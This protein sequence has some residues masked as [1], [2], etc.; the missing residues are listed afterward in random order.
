MHFVACHTVQVPD[1]GYMMD[2]YDVSILQPKAL[3]IHP[4]QQ[5]V[6]P[7]PESQQSQTQ[8]PPA[9]IAIRMPVTG[10]C[11]PVDSTA[12]GADTSPDTNSRM[13]QASLHKGPGHQPSHVLRAAIA[14]AP[15]TSTPAKS[16]ISTQTDDSWNGLVHVQQVLAERE[17]GQK[18]LIQLKDQY[19]VQEARSRQLYHGQKEARQRCAVLEL[20]VQRLKLQI[21]SLQQ[22]VHGEDHSA[23]TRQHDKAACMPIGNDS[24]GRSILHGLHDPRHAQHSSAS[25]SRLSSHVG[26]HSPIHTAEAQSSAH[27]LGMARNMCPAGPYTPSQILE[28]CTEA[29]QDIQPGMVRGSH[30]VA[31]QLGAQVAFLGRAGKLLD[32][33]YMPNSSS[34]SSNEGDGVGMDPDDKSIQELAFGMRCL[35]IEACNAKTASCT[36]SLLGPD[37]W[38]EKPTKPC[39]PAHSTPEPGSRPRASKASG[40]MSPARQPPG[41]ARS[42]SPHRAQNFSI[43]HTQHAGSASEAITSSRTCTARGAALGG[44]H[45]HVDQTTFEPWHVS[46]VERPDRADRLRQ[47]T[48]GS[49]AD[50]AGK[51]TALLAGRGSSSHAG[52]SRVQPPQGAATQ[53]PSV[54]APSAHG[55]QPASSKA[56]K[57]PPDQCQ[58]GCASHPL[59]AELGM[60]QATSSTAIR[61]ATSSSATH[62]MAG[63][64]RVNHTAAADPDV[65]VH[66]VSCNTWLCSAK[67]I[68]DSTMSADG[69]RLLWVD[70]QEWHVRPAPTQVEY[71]LALWC[72]VQGCNERVG[73]LCLPPAPG[74]HAAW[75]KEVPQ[76]AWQRCETHGLPGAMCLRASA[77]RL[78]KGLQ[79]P[80]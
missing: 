28:G 34:R 43:I 71:M 44:G 79:Q 45:G 50:S 75:M 35:E 41:P 77:C 51:I 21:H 26:V 78:V 20:E 76:A 30:A 74:V 57:C 10:S 59:S 29:E 69:R 8:V 33:S 1:A 15:D 38:P 63:P 11:A 53:C 17:A 37:G 9:C 6:V 64:A 16:A 73:R 55:S 80:C 52:G 24:A 31:D 7:Q 70:L 54:A 47:E 36:H 60:Q 62:A 12:N 23:H 58:A 42:A 22:Q 48:H 4:T 65:S 13:R 5:A 40:T 3:S 61:T 25:H 32:G 2:V 68:Y 39:Q 49:T 27:G 72:P 19:D 56:L 66:C 46:C 14:D 67:H 18:T